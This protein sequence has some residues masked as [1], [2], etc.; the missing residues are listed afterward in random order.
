MKLHP[1]TRSRWAAIGAAVAVTVGAGG[2]IPAVMAAENDTSAFTAVVPCRHSD[3]RTA[4]NPL[5][6]GEERTL[7]ATGHQGDCYVPDSATAIVANI[8]AVNPSQDTHVSAYPGGGKR[9]LTATV[10]TASGDRARA[11]SATVKLA[12]DGTFA[13][14]NHAGE[15]DLV[16]DIT[17]F[18]TPGTSGPQG[19]QGDQGPQ[20]PA[21]VVSGHEVVSE[22]SIGFDPWPGHWVTAMCPE[23][24]VLTGG[25]GHGLDLWDH[26][27]VPVSSKPT[28][29]GQGWEV[30]RGS[31]YHGEILLEAYA[32]CV[33]GD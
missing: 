1:L 27:P 16:I 5:G 4:D 32:I 13:V 33:D 8:I 21:G 20:G 11:N 14:W 22:M 24:K 15:V 2:V 7:I 31:G 25:G 26:E 6:A 19:P 23:G 18:Y 29:N 30:S 3:T 17:G 10:N 28:E 9:P 12:G